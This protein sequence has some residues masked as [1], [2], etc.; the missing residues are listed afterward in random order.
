MFEKTYKEIF[1]LTPNAL[2]IVKDDIVVDCNKSFTL[3]LGYSEKEEVLSSIYSSFSPKYQT[4]GS[5]SLSLLEKYLLK[6]VELDGYKFEWIYLRKDNHKI[7]CE[8]YF[9]PMDKG[10]LL[11]TIKDI[12]KEKR[13]ERELLGLN[14]SL[15]QNVESKVSQLHATK[16]LLETVF[17]TTKDAIAIVDENSYYIYVNKSFKNMTGYSEKELYNKSCLD[18]TLEEDKELTKEIML[19]AK[20]KGFYLEYRKPCLVNHDKMI[21]VT[22]DLAMMPDNHSYL[23][24]ARDVTQENQL[25]KEKLLQNQKL[26]QQSR[27]A[28][29]GEMISMIAHQWRQPLAAIS[30]TS[31]NLQ[32]KIE[33]ESFDFSSK[34]GIKE[35]SEYFHV[36][37]ENINDFVHNLTTTIDDFRNFYKPNKQLV[38]IKLHTV[39]QKALSIIRPSLVNDNIELIEEYNDKEE[40]Q[41]YD[42]EIMHVVLNIVKNSQDN[43]K[44]KKKKRAYIKITSSEKKVTIEDNGGGINSAVIEKIFD[45]YFSTKDEKNGTGLGLYMSRTIIEEHHKGILSVQNTDDGVCFSIKLMQK[46]EV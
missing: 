2:L 41:I 19:E 29:M 27:L 37:L 11:I 30:T 10:I 45:P 34:E 23:I 18:L 39:I 5:D 25:H 38:R 12:T 31:V 28:Q 1:E 33:L 3:M 26:L 32:M 46:R 17:N 42:S 9:K 21:E 24:V 13:L 44:D 8:V 4:D 16:E 36:R 20:T 22:M 14:K 6:A 7:E 43:F 40:I 35:A 15:E